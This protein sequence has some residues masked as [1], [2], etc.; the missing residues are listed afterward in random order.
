MRAHGLP[1]FPDPNSQGNLLIGPASGIDPSTPQ[2]KTADHD[3]AK[4]RAAAAGTGMTP[5]Q[6]AQALARLTRFAQCMREHG[7]PMANPFSGPNG[8]VGYALPRG[9]DPNSP[10][11][12]RAESACPGG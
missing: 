9:V 10:A 2:Y 1:D 6:Q 12:K 4:L 11:Y 3:C 7:I 8:G 5:A